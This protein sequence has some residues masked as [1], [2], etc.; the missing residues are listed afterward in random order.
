MS[1]KELIK[2]VV[3]D[4][5]TLEA[6]G[7]RDFLDDAMV[8]AEAKIVLGERE[9]IMI[10]QVGKPAERYQAILTHM[11]GQPSEVIVVHDPPE[12]EA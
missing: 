9:H 5:D 1:T 6:L 8:L 3:Y 4:P 10:S 12:E 7:Q 11:E 2:W